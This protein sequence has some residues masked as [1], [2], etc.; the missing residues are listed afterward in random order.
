MEYKEMEVFIPEMPETAIEFSKAVGK[1]AEQH[2]LRSVEMEIRIDTGHGTKYQ[3]RRFDESLAETLTVS[4]S[5][6]D[7]RGR[8]RTQISVQA[9]IKMRKQI[10]HEP[11]STD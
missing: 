3:H 10:V 8:P 1:L 9:D 11:D 6:V 4:I 2:C 7:G 5:R